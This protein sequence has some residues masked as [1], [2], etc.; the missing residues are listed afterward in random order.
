MKA[1]SVFQQKRA[2]INNYKKIK[3][4]KALQTHFLITIVSAITQKSMS[5]I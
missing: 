4:L 2:A 3:K 1:I 5:L